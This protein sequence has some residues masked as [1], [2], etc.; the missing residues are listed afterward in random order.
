MRLCQRFTNPPIDFYVEPLYRM[1][2]YDYSWLTQMW[3]IDFT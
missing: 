2:A 3:W 1:S